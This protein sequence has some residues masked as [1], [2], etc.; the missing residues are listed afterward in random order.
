MLGDF[1]TAED[2]AQNAFLAAFQ[3]LSSLRRRAA[4][5]AWMLKIARRQDQNG[6]CKNR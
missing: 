6:E 4:F 3:N 1:H 2:A 5:G